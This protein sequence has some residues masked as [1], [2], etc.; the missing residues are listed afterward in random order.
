MRGAFDF[1]RNAW[2]DRPST[3]EVHDEAPR[4]PS[5]GRWF[6][7]AKPRPRTYPW[8]LAASALAS[9]VMLAAFVAG[10]GVLV[11]LAGALCILL[12]ACAYR[13]DRSRLRGRYPDAYLLE[14]PEDRNVCL[15]E[16][17]IVRAGREIGEDRG[18]AWF[19]GDT[20]YYSGFRTSFVIGGE[21]VLPKAH[22]TI[23]HDPAGMLTLPERAIPLGIDRFATYVVFRPIAHADRSASY[24]QELS[25]VRRLMTFRN[26][27]KGS[28]GP[29][30]WPPIEP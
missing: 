4:P 17:A 1:E 15:V 7:S 5:P 21:N 3:L 30:Q 8:S 27:P 10:H 28:A 23:F 14:D 19:R 22:W 26:A 13:I 11:F 16:I 2:T 6:F 25:F 29:R 12:C 20:L 18:A 9:A 24:S